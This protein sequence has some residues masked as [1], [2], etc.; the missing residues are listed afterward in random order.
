MQKLVILLLIFLS[1]NLLYSQSNWVPQEVGNGISVKL[2]DKPIYKLQGKAGIYTASTSNNFFMVIVQYDVIP[3]YS[4]FVMLST[5]KQEELIQV[6]LD[7]TIK[8]VLKSAG[9]EQLP[10]QQL[11]LGSYQGR[12]TNYPSINPSTGLPTVKFCNLY[13]ASN[14]VYMFQCM[15][16]KDAGTSSPE[17]DQFLNSLKTN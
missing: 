3:N 16:L 9:Y 8:G 5:E 2:P 17:K 1:R 12:Q 10:F 11:S 7:N 6:F 15:Y 4:D 14:K 13:Y